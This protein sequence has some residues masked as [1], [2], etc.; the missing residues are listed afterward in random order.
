[1]EKDT[2]IKFPVN[3]SGR[4]PVII[5]YDKLQDE[6]KGSIYLSTIKFC[7]EVTNEKVFAELKKRN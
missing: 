6:S 3:D 5:L 7:A 2:V 1:M 4:L